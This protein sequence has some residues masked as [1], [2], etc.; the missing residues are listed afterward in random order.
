MTRA[1]VVRPVAICLFKHN[2]KILAGEG[3]DSVKNQIF[4]RPLGGSIEFGER[5]EQTIIRELMEETGEEVTDIRFLAV[6]ENIFTYD[7]LDMHEIIF[8]YDG[9]FVNGSVYEKEYLEVDEDGVAQRAYW[10]ET[11]DFK[12]GKYIL[13]PEK[14]L[15]LF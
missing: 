10:R 14:L 12:S 9:R 8:I 2:G 1:K 5:A 15:E 11:D 7:G 4:Y 13:Y 3:I 6:A